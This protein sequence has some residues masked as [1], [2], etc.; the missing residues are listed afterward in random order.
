M[1]T[2]IVTICLLIFTSQVFAGVDWEKYDIC[3]K[4]SEEITECDNIGKSVYRYNEYLK[5]NLAIGPIVGVAYIERGDNRGTNNRRPAE[6]SGYYYLIND[7]GDMKNLITTWS[8]D[9]EI[10]V[11]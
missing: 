8:L 11:K 5:K 4:N 10:S 3:S 2:K 1:K 9:P 6:F 7:T